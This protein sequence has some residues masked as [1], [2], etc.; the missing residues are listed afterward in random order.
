[1]R[2]LGSVENSKIH[3]INRDET[4]TI[5]T[6]I[7]R[8]VSFDPEE[9]IAVLEDLGNE[10]TD[11]YAWKGWL[12]LKESSA[13]RV[14]NE[15]L[16]PQFTPKLKGYLRTIAARG[17]DKVTVKFEDFN[18]LFLYA[19]LARTYRNKAWVVVDN[20]V[21]GREVIKTLKAKYVKDEPGSWCEEQFLLFSRDDF[22]EYYPAEFQ[23]KARRILQR[24]DGQHKQA[25][26][27]ALLN[28][29][30][31]YIKDDEQ[32]AREA[33]ELAAGEVIDLLQSIEKV[34]CPSEA[35]VTSVA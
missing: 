17:V 9:R 4:Q 7:Y 19:H 32:K 20:G 1:M 23:E 25:A 28:E 24:S 26:K 31:E 30:L 22:E 12:I 15:F 33:F 3:Y 29:V 13:E 2:Y 27:T 5:P 34:L 35:A 6:A 21:R 11:L 16:I 18:S 14:I 8:E 10:M